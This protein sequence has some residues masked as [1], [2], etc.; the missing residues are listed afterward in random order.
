[1]EGWTF[2][3][4]HEQVSPM[5]WDEQ[6][7]LPNFYWPMDQLKNRSLLCLKLLYCCSCIVFQSSGQWQPAVT[8]PDRPRTGQDWPGQAWPGQT[9]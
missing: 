2:I 5:D 3:R 9:G 1:M 6:S 4:H 8:W 7:S